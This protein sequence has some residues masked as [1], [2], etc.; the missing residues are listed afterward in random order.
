MTIPCK[1]GLVEYHVLQDRFV[2]RQLLGKC[3]FQAIAPSSSLQRTE[4][5][6]EMVSRWNGKSFVSVLEPI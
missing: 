6:L 2:E 5:M 3:V 4:Q 1:S